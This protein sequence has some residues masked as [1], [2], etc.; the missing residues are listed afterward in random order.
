MDNFFTKA[1]KGFTNGLTNKHTYSMQSHDTTGLS[2]VGSFFGWVIGRKDFNTYVKAYGEN[3]LVY[4]IVKRIAS[5]TAGIKRVVIDENT[6]EP[7]DNSELLDILKNPNKDQT[8]IDF[9][10][11]I[12]EY[13]LLSGNTYIHKTRSIGGLGD[14]HDV[15]VAQNVEILCDS[16]GEVAG[17]KYT[18]PNGKYITY[19]PDDVLHIKTSNVVNVDETNIKYGLSPLEASW[20]VV[21]SSS[22]KL[23]ADASIF[24]NRGIVGI[25]TNNSDNAMLPNERKRLQE[26]YDAEAAGADKFNKIKVSTTKLQ[27]IQ[28]GMSPSD[29]KLLEGILSSLRLLCSVYGISSILFN[30]N[31]NSTFN[32]VAE[33]KSSAY[34][35]VF[36]PLAQKVD[37]QLS[38]FMSEGE[39]LRVD[40]DSIEEVAASTNK[41][42]DA[43]NTL[44][45][46][47]QVKIISVMTKDEAREIIGLDSLT[48]NEGSELVGDGKTVTPTE[49]A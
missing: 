20:V 17:Y 48:G 5:T 25:L 4:M 37:A 11:E 33:A 8:Q 16:I 40:I 32:N 45:V 1:L 35:D 9:Y 15:L 44:P 42:I 7:K 22:E 41:T 31:E 6:L 34:I 13:L 2:V 19:P 43:I 46:Q 21:Q 30:D 18:L 12:Y 47:A 24:K 49:N 38:R 28:T 14:S 29:L 36:I 26:E 27:Y 39:E 3:A 10:E 23:K